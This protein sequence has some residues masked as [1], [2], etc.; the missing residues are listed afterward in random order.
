MT[1]EV[2]TL[3][4]G[5]SFV[6]REV[7]SSDWPFIWSSW[8]RQIRSKFPFHAFTRDEFANHK[9]VVIEH[10]SKNAQCIIAH[11]PIDADGIYGYCVYERWDDCDVVHAI[12]IKGGEHSLRG[13]GIGTALMRAVFSEFGTRPLWCTY[14]GQSSKYLAERWGLRYNPYILAE[15]GTG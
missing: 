10:L 3:P 9:D 15:E 5:A 8:C 1:G 4:S 11:D 6:L 14:L 12:Y 7:R 2:I 13:Y